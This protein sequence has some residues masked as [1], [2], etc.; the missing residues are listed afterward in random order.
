MITMT[1][2]LLRSVAVCPFWAADPIDYLFEIPRRPTPR[3]VGTIVWP[4]L[5]GSV[6]ANDMSVT[7]NNAAEA[8]EVYLACDDD[9]AAGGL[10]LSSGEV[11]IDPGCC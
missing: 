11:T 10:R 2:V 4:L 8:I 6:I 7:A 3:Q 5:A 1:P 9:Y